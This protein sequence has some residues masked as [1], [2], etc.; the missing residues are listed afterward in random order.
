MRVRILSTCWMF[1]NHIPRAL[2]VLNFWFMC[3]LH[4]CLIAPD[5][6]SKWTISTGLTGKSSLRHLKSNN[7]LV[8][9]FSIVKPGWGLFLYF[10]FL[11][12]S[13]FVCKSRVMSYF[14]FIFTL[15]PNF[16]IHMNFMP[17]NW[18]VR[19]HPWNNEICVPWDHQSEISFASQMESFWPSP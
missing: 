10:P 19:R 12:A 1:P 17:P 15:T 9:I 2:M 16:H 11:Y 6:S 5:L 7:F 8:Q 13:V 4:C 14:L 3:S 18:L